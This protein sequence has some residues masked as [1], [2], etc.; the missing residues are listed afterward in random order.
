[1][2]LDT[3]FSWSN[4]INELDSQGTTGLDCVRVR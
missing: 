3:C 2:Y 1:M 4:N